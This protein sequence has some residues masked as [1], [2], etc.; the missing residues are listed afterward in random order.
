MEDRDDEDDWGSVVDDR[1]GEDDWDGVVDDRDDVEDYW[2]SVSEE[3]DS[4]W[5]GVVEKIYGDDADLSHSD[6]QRGLKQ[7]NADDVFLE[8][9]LVFLDKSL[10]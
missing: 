3:K 6:D 4:D 5:G 2:G 8:S 1:D 10:C 9:I 7:T